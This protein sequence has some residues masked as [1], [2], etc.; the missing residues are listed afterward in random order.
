MHCILFSVF[1]LVLRLFNRLSA[2]TCSKGLGCLSVLWLVLAQQRSV[3]GKFMQKL[4][5]M[6]SH[7]ATHSIGN[8]L[9]IIKFLSVLWSVSAQER[10]VTGKFMQKL[11]RML[12][13]M[14]LHSIDNSLR[15]IQFLLPCA[16]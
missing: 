15:M 1:F 12:T 8:P 6:L 10:N 14:Q 9:P 7:A 2:C 3:T 13:V 5:R 16:V 4:M 11:M